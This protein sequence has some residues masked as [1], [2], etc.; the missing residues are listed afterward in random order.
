MC[1]MCWG[2]L[3][4]TGKLLRTVFCTEAER[5]IGCHR[6]HADLFLKV[7]ERGGYKGE[8]GRGHT[9]H[10]LTSSIASMQTK[11][12]IT[13]VFMHD[14][15]N[16]RCVHRIGGV[17]VSACTKLAVTTKNLLWQKRHVPEFSG[18][19][20]R[21]DVLEEE[22]QEPEHVFVSSREELPSCCL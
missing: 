16:C 12:R 7:C 4:H 19:D 3:S 5:R 17:F 11:Q 10:T 22:L 2:N 6:L 18:A 20:P 13:H 15:H 21:L 9:N 14:T 8:G 1:G